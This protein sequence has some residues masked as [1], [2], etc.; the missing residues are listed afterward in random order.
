M[1][2]KANDGLTYKID[3]EHRYPEW[4]GKMIPGGIKKVD[5][6]GTSCFI[7]IVAD[8]DECVLIGSSRLN[9]YYKDAWSKVMGRKYSLAEAMKDADLPK[10]IRTDI[11]KEYI[12]THKV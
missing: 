6:G 10:N 8:K 7:S 11:W 3:F 5:N 2:V 4:S 1:I 9:C 12:K